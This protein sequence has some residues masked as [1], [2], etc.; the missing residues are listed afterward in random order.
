MPAT[1]FLPLALAA[2]AAAVRV[3]APVQ[4]ATVSACFGLTGVNESCSVVLDASACTTSP[5]ARLV[6]IFSGGEMGCV[7]GTGYASVLANYS[8]SGWAAACVDYFES[9]TGSGAAPYYQERS[10]LDAAVAATTNGSWA[11]AY[12]TREY[13]L[14]Q[15]ISHGASSPLIVISRFGADR[16]AFWRGTRGTAG[17]FFDGSVNQSASAELLATGGAGGQPCSFPVPYSRWLERYCGTPPPVDCDLA[18][19][20]DAV[21]DLVE[22]APASNFS[23]PA[24][25]LYECGSLLSPCLGDIIP[26]GP[27]ERLCARL[28][29]GGRACEF[30]RLP[31]DSHLTCHRD[32]GYECRGWAEAL[33]PLAVSPS[34]SA[35][36]ASASPLPTATPPPPA[37][38]VSAMPI[39]G[40]VIGGVLVTIVFASAVFAYCG[41]CRPTRTFPHANPGL[42]QSFARSRSELP[43]VEEISWHWFAGD[44]SETLPK[45]SPAQ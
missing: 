12:W 18:T 24:W 40:G 15:G 23:I 8:R 39:I 36:P 6:V 21:L 4:V 41:G 29:N 43:S 31:Y 1:A 5:C 35:S 33:F 17:C 30:R 26:R 10:R 3:P 38:T 9:S 11:E 14:L 37:T 22:N 44:R 2:A 45:G 34:A 20:A 13:L 27:F 28:N 19:N 32:H 25:R 16:Q 7:N 42:Q